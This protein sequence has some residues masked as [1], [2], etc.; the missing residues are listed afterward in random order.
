MDPELK[1]LLKKQHYAPVGK[2]SG[3]KLCHWLKKSL[4]QDRHCYKQDFYGIQS[5]RCLQF[6]PA[7]N[8]CTQ[9][10]IFCWRFQQNTEKEINKPDEPSVLLDEAVKAQQKLLSGYKGNPQVDSKRWEEANQ[11]RLLACSLVGEPT[12]YSWLGELF[13]E[14]RRRDITTFLVTN[15]TKPEVLEQ[16]DALPDQLYITVAA[17]N[18]DVYKKLCRPLI[19]DGWKKLM[20]TLNLAPSLDTRIVIRHTLVRGWNMEGYSRDYARL[21]AIAQPAFI[22]PKG[23]MFIGGSRQR[24]SLNE[25]PSHAEIKDFSRKLAAEMGYEYVSEKPDSRVVLLRKS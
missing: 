11:P 10:C 6:S 5:H 1:A 3:V 19:K 15:G 18:E 12:I 4:I 25:M 13:E 22:E 20:E 7:V 16:M 9:Q 2:H 8:H 14:C 17:P 24:L 21:D 23:Y